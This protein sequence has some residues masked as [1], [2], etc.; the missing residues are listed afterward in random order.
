MGPSEVVTDWRSQGINIESI[1]ITELIENRQ[2][3][4]LPLLQVKLKRI[5]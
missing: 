2:Q 5:L 3:D 4:T 1:D